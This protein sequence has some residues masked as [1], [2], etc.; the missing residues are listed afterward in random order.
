MV[1]PYILNVRFIPDFPEEPLR[2][3]IVA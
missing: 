3:D 1:N 2:I